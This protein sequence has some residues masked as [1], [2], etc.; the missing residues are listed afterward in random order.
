MNKL[1]QKIMPFIWG[2]LM[3]G[4]LLFTYYFSLWIMSI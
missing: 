2:A 4:L 3:M 1:N